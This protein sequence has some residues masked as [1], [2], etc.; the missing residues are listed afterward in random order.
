MSTAK[1]NSKSQQELDRVSDQFDKF[2]EQVKS[3]TQDEMSKAPIADFEP[4]TKISAREANKVDAQYIK[5]ARSINSK[6]QFNEKYRNEWEAKKKYVRCIVENREI[7]GEKVEC[8]SKPFPGV[9]AEFWQIPVNKP[10]YIPQHLAEQLA[11][12]CYHRLMMDESKSVSADGH[13][14]YYGAIT[15]KETIQRIDARPVGF[16]FVAM[17]G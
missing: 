2:D 5:P 11:S 10:I 6:E 8:W 9:A 4:Q 15:V 13:G 1:V 7:I 12:R 16:G 14:T 17:A 3:L